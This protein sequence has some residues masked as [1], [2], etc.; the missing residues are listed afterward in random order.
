MVDKALGFDLKICVISGVN[1]EDA[2]DKTLCPK[3]RAGTQS[4]TC[5]RS[6]GAMLKG[7]HGS[8]RSKSA[9]QA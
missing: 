3:E 1:Q 5:P 8:P 6:L 2:D 9:S 7:G 4:R